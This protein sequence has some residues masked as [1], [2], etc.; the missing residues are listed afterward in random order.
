MSRITNHLL[1]NLSEAVSTRADDHANEAN[2]WVSV[3]WNIDSFIIADYRSSTQQKISQNTIN[4]STT[5][6]RIGSFIYRI[7][8]CLQCFEAVGW[9][10]GWA[11]GL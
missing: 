4:S 2:L 6:I 7:C 1:L 11:Y 5:Y 10:A 9:A 8:L 3:L